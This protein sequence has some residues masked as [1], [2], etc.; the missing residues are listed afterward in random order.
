MKIKTVFPLF[1]M[2]GLFAWWLGSCNP[3]ESYSNVPEIRFKSLVIE[4]RIDDPDLGNLLKYVIL[5]FS[6]IDGDG[7][8]GV[9]P[10]DVDSISRIYYTWYQKLPGRRYEPYQFEDGSI[11]NSSLI[12]YSSVMD[13]REA[14]NKILKGSIEIVMDML[15]NTPQ[16]VDTMR[17][18]FFIVDRA[19]NESNPELTPDFSILSTYGKVE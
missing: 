6:F 9:S 4:D 10:Q 16:G 19:K 11:T 12:P 8:I 14:Q 17:I 7:D 18:E 1:C 2:L 3:P 15:R 5:T 13:K